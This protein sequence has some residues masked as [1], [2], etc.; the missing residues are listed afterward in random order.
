MN[1]KI[2][3]TF[4]VAMVCLFYSI[5]AEGQDTLVYTVE[6]TVGASGFMGNE[7][8][9]DISE[10]ETFVA[11]FLIDTTVPDSLINDPDEGRYEGAILTSSLTFSGGFVDD[12]TDFAGS[13]LRVLAF[14]NSNSIIFEI[15]DPSEPD[16]SLA[17]FPVPRIFRMIQLS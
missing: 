3:N 16:A 10:G 11:Q 6:G 2:T 1:T 4:L 12:Q 5:P 13:D 17:L 15:P 9:D 8:S 7:L 14:P